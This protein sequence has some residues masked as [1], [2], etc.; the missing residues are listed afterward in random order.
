MKQPSTGILT[1][2]IIP[3]GRALMGRKGF[4]FEE[5]NGGGGNQGGAHQGDPNPPGSGDFQGRQQPQQQQ[6]GNQEPP[7]PFKD[8]DLDLLDPATRS[9][10]ER[11]RTE[12]ARLNGQAKLASSFQS[13]RDR[14]KAEHEKLQQSLHSMQ[15]QQRQHQ[16]QQQRQ[17]PTFEDELIDNLVA[18]GL[19]P[20]QAKGAAKLQMGM[21]ERFERRFEGKIGQRLAPVVGQVFDQQ[22][23]GAFEEAKQN[24]H[25]GA[26]DIPEVAEAVWK[27]ISE[28][29]QQGRQVTPEVAENLTAIYYSRYLRET[30]GQMPTNG[31]H[32]SRQ[33][34]SQRPNLP[35]PVNTNTRY[36]YP[37]AGIHARPPQQ[38]QKGTPVSADEAVA[39]AATTA[40][41]PVQPKAYAGATPQN[42]VFITRNGESSSRGS[43]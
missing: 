19:T 36:S 38:Q 28:L 21:F 12:M 4:F 17:E 20:E 2:Q 25:F 42:G 37:G 26:M 8:L 3:S 41:W 5:D 15:N 31:E 24:D 43:R 13:D 14:L 30:G 16:Q 27:N 29:A 18:N 23:Q 6:G 32:Q 22:A 39:M 7:D 33:Q 11:G 34:Q 35:P 10:I 40:L 9:A 1:N